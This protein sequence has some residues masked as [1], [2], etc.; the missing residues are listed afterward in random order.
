M[1]IQPVKNMK[2]NIINE[3]NL[4]ENYPTKML[5]I[6]ICKE[7]KIIGKF[8]SMHRS[9][10]ILNWLGA[11]AGGKCIIPKTRESKRPVHWA[12]KSPNLGKKI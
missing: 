9:S 12:L 10:F 3:L 6:N 1:F 7:K 4:C 2:F 11:C 8:V 5:L